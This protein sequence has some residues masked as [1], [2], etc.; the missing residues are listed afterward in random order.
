VTIRP[1]AWLVLAVTLLVGLLMLADATSAKPAP[2]TIDVHPGKHAIEKALDGANG[3]DT[4]R[5]HPGSYGGQV[6]VT[7]RVK[8]V[9]VGKQR[10]LV[11]GKC[12]TNDTIEIQSAGVVVK[13]LK[14]VG[15]AEGFGRFSSEVNFD[16]VPRGRA[17]D[18]VVK[19]TCDAEYGINV[20]KGGKQQIVGNRAKGFS[21]SGIYIGQIADTHG[22]S[23]D[24]KANNTYG[25]SRGIIVEFS[26]GVAIHLSNND[27]HDNT[28]KGLGES[29]PAGILVNG[30]DGVLFKANRST[31]NGRYGIDFIAGS[32]DNRLVGNDFRGNPKAIHVDDTSGHNC[33]S[34]NHPNPFAHC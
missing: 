33:G 10:P 15:A 25:N 12:R 31:A 1:A 8:L 23:L 27:T 9:G 3:G 6:V 20:I 30:S 24:V 19:D 2:R 26:H 16:A 5:I 4:L 29:P 7:K 14:V 18:L 17:E 34:A 13:H 11:D 32:H 22:G 21:D 28:L